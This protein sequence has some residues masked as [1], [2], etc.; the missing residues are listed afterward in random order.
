MAFWTRRLLLIS[1]SMLL[2]GACGSAESSLRPSQTEPPSSLE[3]SPSVPAPPSSGSVETTLP[4]D[5]APTPE[6]EH[7]SNY[8]AALADGRYEDAATMTSMTTSELIDEI[9]VLPREQFEGLSRGALLEYACWFNYRLCVEPSSVAS[10]GD[11][12]VTATFPDGASQTG[13]SSAA[14]RWQQDAGVVGLPPRALI[15]AGRCALGSNW[16]PTCRKSDRTL[17]ATTDTT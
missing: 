15:K 8:L 5:P 7:V 16:T 4:A 9:G 1:A 3:T 2:V 13:S 6:S 11:G 17:F 10:G 12:L 14:F